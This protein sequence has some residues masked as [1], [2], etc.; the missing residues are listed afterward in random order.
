MLYHYKYPCE[1][2]RVL[3]CSF[4]FCRSIALCEGYGAFFKGSLQRCMLV[5]P[6]F[7]IS[8]TFYEMQQRFLNK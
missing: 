1:L 4:H 8:L 6:L 2:G 7:G 5:A 3:K